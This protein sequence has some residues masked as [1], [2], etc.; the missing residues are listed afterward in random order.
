MGKGQGMENPSLK[1]VSQSFHAQRKEGE[2]LEEDSLTFSIKATE[3]HGF[4]LGGSEPYSNPVPACLLSQLRPQLFLIEHKISY[5]ILSSGIGFL[6][7]SKWILNFLP[8]E[9]K[10]W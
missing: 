9:A 10:L 4:E 3:N 7:A 2:Q 5:L 8:K 1:E 6:F